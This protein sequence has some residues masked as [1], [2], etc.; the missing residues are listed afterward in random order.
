MEDDEI[1]MTCVDDTQKF[2]CPITK[3]ELVDP[4]KNKLCGHSFSRKAVEAH[5]KNMKGKAKCPIAGCVS[6]ITLDDLEK[7]NVLA[8]EMRKRDRNQEN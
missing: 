8:F 2:V 5:I 4:V 1:E 6:A 3:G 7:N